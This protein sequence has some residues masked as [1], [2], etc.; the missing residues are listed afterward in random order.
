MNRII[1]WQTAFRYLRGKRSANAVPILSRVSMLAI[2]VG[3]C[4]MI[5]LFSVFNGFEDVVKDLY[6]AFYPDIKIAAARGKFFQADDQRLAK[7][8]QVEGVNVITPVIED[9]VLVNSEDEQIVVTLK[10]I[11]PSY[12]KVND[13]SPY[14]VEGRDS[15]AI[16]PAPT[17]IVGQHIEAQLGVDVNNV[18]SRL[19]LYYPNA[20]ANFALNPASAFQ[21]LRLRPDGVF[22]V[23]DDFDG[24]YVLA[25]LPLAQQLFNQPGKLSAY[26]IKLNP[27]TDQE[28][29]KSKIK[30]LLGDRFSVET[31]FEQNRMLYVVMRTEKWAVYAILLLVLLIASF[32]MVGGLSLLVLE[33]EK[34]MAI[35]QTMGA[36]RGTIRGIILTEGILWALTGGLIGIVIGGL[37][38]LGQQHF[39]WKK[40]EGSFIIDA[41]PVSMQLTDFVLV[42]VT[43]IVVGLLAA[44]YP[45][46]RSG[47]IESAAM[48]RS[49]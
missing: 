22:H 49:A 40:L 28:A 1:V 24:K 35:L 44:L 43:V 45:A 42:I 14:I 38:C 11:E 17:A 19:N 10:G 36:D 20:D 30:K 13:L 34:D 39:K 32:N 12:F 6:K 9:N 37:L 3:S 46:I 29:V 5:V 47:K 16:D 41:Y 7:L 15:V 21:S 48:L 18:F 2:A 33:K 4:A 25:R 27:G 31:R 26:E 8:R 23:Q